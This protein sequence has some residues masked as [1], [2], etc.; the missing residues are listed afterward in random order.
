MA[1]EPDRNAEREAEKAEREAE[2][3]KRKAGK[4]APKVEKPIEASEPYPTGN[5]PDPED[6]FEQA[7]GFRREKA[8]E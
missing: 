1:R 4:E 3:T 5:P 8:K 6:V 2:E 7:H